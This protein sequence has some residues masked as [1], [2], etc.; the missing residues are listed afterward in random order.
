MVKETSKQLYEAVQYAIQSDY[1]IYDKQKN[2]YARLA[3]AKDTCIFG[4]GQF[5]LDGYPYIKDVVKAKYICD[6]NIDKVIAEKRNTYGLECIHVYELEK[7]EDILV[8]IMLGGGYCEVKDQLDKK[9]IDNIYV[10]DLVLNMYSPKYSAEWFSA[11]C[12][13]I[14]DTLELFEDDISKEN[15]VEI[16]CNRIAPHLRKKS[17]EEIKSGGGYFS[18][19][20][21]EYSNEEV[22]VDVGAYIGDTI[23]EFCS[24]FKKEQLEYKHIYAFELD[25]GTCKCL[26]ENVARMNVG[27]IDIYQKGIGEKTDETIGILN[28]DSLFEDKKITLLKMDIEGY[29]WGALHGGIKSIQK[30]K[31]KMAVCV[32]HYLEDLWRIPQF[33]KQL[34]PE[35]KLYLRHRSPVVWD[36]VL[37]ASCEEIGKEK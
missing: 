6:N 36:S 18:T 28:L 19:G 17:F 7:K 37:Y 4:A 30:W 24:Y 8:V 2:A 29:E 3:T 25:P 10:G 12:D 23:D 5:F 11:Q 33:I 14:M 21:F 1:N 31:P 13:Q 26:Q 20:L 34:N 35:Y 32:Y 27:N 9:G 22:Y 15:Y 16:I